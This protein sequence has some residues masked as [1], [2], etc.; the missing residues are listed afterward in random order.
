MIT[1]LRDLSAPLH[2][3]P[4]ALAVPLLLLASPALAAAQVVHDHGASPY[5]ELVDREIAALSAEETAGLRAGEGMGMALPAELNAYPGPKHV[6]ELADSLGLTEE[7]AAAVEAAHD[8]MA[9]A[10][11]TLGERVIEAERALDRLF[12]DGV[13]TDEAVR[14][15]TAEVA[16]LRGELRAVH[17]VAH[18]RTR[19]ALSRHQLHEYQRLRRYAGAHEHS[20]G[21][22]HASGAGQGPSGG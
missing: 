16:R 22:E 11:V 10:A 20:G 4:A 19:E 1:L 9:G 7:Q 13:A 17:L 21:L 14:A 3:S 5:A 12:A 2:L 8:E 18:L 6:L 15:A